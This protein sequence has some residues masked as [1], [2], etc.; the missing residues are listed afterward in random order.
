MGTVWQRLIRV[1]DIQ[2]SDDPNDRAEL[3]IFE[4]NC[5]IFSYKGCQMTQVGDKR[6]LTTPDG[7]QRR[8]R[9]WEKNING[10]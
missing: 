4:D 6:Y 10:T 8:M 9:E 7:S 1:K 5:F 2:M 3:C